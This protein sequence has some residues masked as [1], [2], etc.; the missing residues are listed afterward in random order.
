[1]QSRVGASLA[2][3]LI[4]AAA[5][6]AL[7]CTFPLPEAIPG[8]SQAS[9]NRR[10]ESFIRQWSED[11]SRAW[12]RDLFDQASRI[13][14]ARVV[15]RRDTG[16]VAIISLRQSAGGPRGYEA[17]LLPVASLKGPLPSGP[18]TAKW[19]H[20]LQ[21]R[22][23]EPGRAAAS[24]VGTMVFLFDRFGSGALTESEGFPVSMV[25]DPRLIEALRRI[26][27][28]LKDGAK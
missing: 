23:F 19:T 11:G 24:P 9:W 20:Q 2:A 14:L 21:C 16:G 8:E 28:R 4:S 12:Q 1:M 18:V 3:G 22:F 27:G 15:R 26:P 6:P 17:D 7:A 10:Q 25:R 5:A 13:S